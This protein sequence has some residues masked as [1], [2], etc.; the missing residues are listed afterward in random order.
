MAKKICPCSIFC[1]RSTV[2]TVVL[3]A[4][5]VLLASSRILL[6]K[7]SANE[8][9][10]YEYQPAT[11]NL[12]AEAVKLVV[13]A[14]LAVRVMIQESRSYKDCRCTSWKDFLSYLKWAVPAFLYF[15]DN[16]IIFYVLS[17][18]QPAMATLFSNFVIITTAMLFRVVLKRRLSWVQWAS[19]LILF[20]SI[21]SLNMGTD[22]TQHSI[23]AHSLIHIASH[24]PSNS[25]SH[26]LQ[27]EEHFAAGVNTSAKPFPVLNWNPESLKKIH[28]S[29]GHLLI[30]V[31]CF[32]ASMANIYSEKIFKEGEQLTESIFIQNFKLY[33]FG[34]LFNGLT[35]TLRHEYHSQILNCGFFYGHNVF[36]ISLIF[37]TAFLGLSVAF[38]LKF[39]DNMFHVLT[40]QITTVI[41][42]TVSIFMFEF[43]PTMEFFLE[44]P[45][46]LLSIFIYNRTKVRDP[47][48]ALQKAKLKVLNGEILERSSG[49]GEELERLT[50][51]NADTETDDDSL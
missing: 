19:L 36:S 39:R 1:S 2:F 51:A 25:C 3:G 32:I 28:L 45:V 42:T 9:N 15:L 43:K 47:E 7:F 33:L 34:V 8:E 11:V 21:V 17:Y 35:L 46:V 27:T 13:C 5:F 38:M 23:P 29:L 49:D 31:Q 6:M 41:I 22:G 12:C 4:V 48:F 20:L 18:F 10:K 40:A 50:K 44:A 30:I 37:V 14:V 24:S 26:F 16:L